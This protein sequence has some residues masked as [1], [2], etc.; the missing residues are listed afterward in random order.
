MA[1]RGPIEG[2]RGFGS[3]GGGASYQVYSKETNSQ[4][5]VFTSTANRDAYF[6]SNPSELVAINNQPLAIGIGAVAEDPSQDN[7]TQWY[8]Y[9][10]GA[11]E[12]IVATL[13]GATGSP[14]MGQIDQNIPAGTVLLAQDDNGEIV[15]GSSSMI[16]SGGMIQST[17]PLQLPGGGALRFDNNDMS[18]GGTVSGGA[19]GVRFT[20]LTDITTGYLVNV[21][22]TTAEG[23]GS[24]FYDRFGPEID[25]PSL[26]D[27]SDNRN[28]EFNF[29]NPLPG[30]VTEYT[31]SRAAGSPT[32][33]N[34]NFII[35]L[36]GYNTGVPLFDYKESNPGGAGF[37]LSAGENTVT[38]PVPIGFPAN[39]DPNAT[40]GEQIRLYAHVVDS[41]GDLVEL[42]G[43]VVTFP[44]NP[45]PRAEQ[46]WIPFLERKVH[47]SELVELADAIEHPVTLRRDMP[48]EEDAQA[49]VDALL[50]GNSALW[51]V[52][53]DQ[54]TTSNRADATIV[55]QRAGFLDLDGNEIPTTP[56][57]ANTIKMRSG[58]TVRIFAANDYRVVDSPV[59]ESDIPQ[60]LPPV[61]ISAQEFTITSTN[62]EDYLDRTIR[63]TNSNT[64][65]I[66]VIRFGSISTFLATNP[67]RDVSFSFIVNRGASNL[68]ADWL[69][70]GAETIGGSTSQRR[71]EDQTITITLPSSGTNWLV[72]S[73]QSMGAGTAESITLSDDDLT[74]ALV[75]S[76]NV[77]EA[78]KRLDNTGIGAAPRE[79][80]GSFFAN[81]GEL[82]N[83]GQW[84]GGR[85]NVIMSGARGQANGNYT[86]ELPN[87]DELNSMFDDQVSRG[88]GETYQITIEY[89]GG[90]SPFINRNSMT[91]RPASV[92]PLF[93]RNQ[94]PTT[95]AQGA[96][97]TFRITRAGGS[98]GNWERL[99]VQQSTDPVA[100]LGEV[101]LQNAGWNNSDGSFLPPSG[102]VQK[103]YAFPV[104]GSNPNDGTLRQGFI[105][106]GVS[107]RLIYDGDYVI[108]T[109]DAFTSWTD[110]DNW[111]V[112]SRDSLQRMSREQSNFLSQTSEIDNRVDLG[113]VGMTGGEALI[114]IS[115]NPLASAPFIDP[116][117]DGSNPRAGDNYRYIGG[118]EDR[119]A[120]LSF[121]FGQNRFN[122]YITVGINPNYLAGHNLDDIFIVTR[123]DE[124][125][126]IGRL[127]L[128]S[129]LTENTGF[130]NSSFRYFQRNT[131]YNY[132]FLATIST[133]LTQVQKHFLINPVTVDVTQ[134]IPDGAINEGKLSDDVAEKLNRALPDPGVSYESIVDRLMTYRNQ[135]RMVPDINAQFLSGSPST[136]YPSDLTGFS[137]VST[138]NPRFQASGTVLFIATPGA[139]GISHV[140]T[141]TSTDTPTPLDQSNIIESITVGG[142]SYFMY[143]VTGI[144]SGNRYE[145]SQVFN[146]RV[147]A[148]R[149][150][151]AANKNSI[152]RIDAELGHAA[153]NLPDAVVHVLE[154]DVTV[155][156][157]SNPVESPTDYNTGLSSNGLQS[158][159]KESNPNAG[160]GGAK[161]SKSYNSSP[162]DGQKL[163]Y[164]NADQ[165][166][167]EGQAVVS[168]FNGLSTTRD[169][170]RYNG[171]V[172][173]ARVRVPAIPASTTSVTI[174]PSPPNRVSGNGIWQNIPTLTFVN[175]IPVTEADELFFTRNIPQ[176]LTTLTIQ[177]RGH[178]NGNLFGQGSFILNGVGGNS[179]VSNSVTINDGSE[180]ATIEIT[181]YPSF[182]GGG[183]QIRASVTERVFTGLPTINDVEVILSYTET[184]TVPA[185]NA[186]TRDVPIETISNSG[187]VFAFVENSDGSLSVIGSDTQAN[188]GWQADTLFA[189]D[190][191]GVFVAGSE[192][193]TFF[194]YNNVSLTTSTVLDLE[195]HSGLPKFG[196]FT[197]NYTRETDLN[198]NVTIKPSGLNI[199]DLP[200]SATGLAS[201]DVWFDGSSLKFVP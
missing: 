114:W 145:V 98:L 90:S 25:A 168:A 82:G 130:A 99:G 97:A 150:D 101:V 62:F 26:S 119:D 22:F 137:Q 81:Y 135:A 93:D 113:T 28:A 23:S 45:D 51:I 189:V 24:P 72:T 27:K 190:R 163:V 58:T 49:I 166:Y 149:T 148:E 96:S 16:E 187:Q 37:T 43:Q 5:A 170:I 41:N 123:D 164:F 155:T 92:S 165:Q 47:F 188:L 66:Q 133:V 185:T 31:V 89:L 85:Q 197:V 34:C 38:P 19:S 129:D 17:A 80:T 138:D 12:T 94:L 4:P 169:L 50:N 106:A 91:I 125:R 29:I 156:E 118:R 95:I 13:V 65:V 105:D 75:N 64:G 162:V 158:V 117:T 198:I 132:P 21:P 154:N 20:N 160:S 201:G 191:K 71:Q 79:F 196:L 48:T 103:G 126:E 2:L 53:N 192:T 35:W 184:R 141:N 56:V 110:G 107:D 181:Y 178:A 151:I 7:V 70:S 30:I 121:Q 3:G 46:Q 87:I 57:A 10:S 84:Y 86:F 18:S 39:I 73:A 147:V 1:Q 157:E 78:L 88:L 140:L 176:S 83:Q 174:Y 44:P 200:T 144:T 116:S 52:A 186:S 183:P 32:L 54:L 139:E 134:N 9:I 8:A 193:A 77:Q 152:A 180:S 142:V 36:E 60:P 68:S 171:G 153:L 74:G 59:F 67:T 146:D 124:G 143:R 108:W 167:A 127:S 15:A 194:D 136:A 112:L 76:G 42:E 100:T 109:A 131:T 63:L 175:G 177:Y 199:N 128:T 122:S 61:E 182:S 159:F 102:A 111:F 33:T 120:N 179:L 69:P 14:G 172:F 55:A 11:W 161:N 40:S 173:N 195:N 6:A 115:E 104:I